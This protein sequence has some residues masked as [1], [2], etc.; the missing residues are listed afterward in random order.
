MITKSIKSFSALL[1]V[2]MFLAT[3]APVMAEEG[4]AQSPAPVV[5]PKPTPAPSQ[6][7]IDGLACMKAAVDKREGAV[8]AAWDTGSASIKTSLTTRQ[9]A[10]N[11]A[12]GI[13]IRKDRNVAL[14]KA[15]RD[16]GVSARAAKKTFN[17]SRYSAWKQFNT[18]GKACKA[19]YGASN[20][21]SLDVGGNSYSDLAL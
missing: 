6:K 3:S 4:V 10:L 9:A 17:S 11:V 14:I 16:F 2:A 21:T 19:K 20:T 5:T 12:W 15:W 18:D 7:L 13:T 1:M 8:I